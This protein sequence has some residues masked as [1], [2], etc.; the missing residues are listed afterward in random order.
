[1]GRTWIFE[2]TGEVRKVR[3]GDYYLDSAGHVQ[4]WIASFKSDLS[5]RILKLTKLSWNPIDPIRAVHEKWKGVVPTIRPPLNDF[6]NQC[7][8]AIKDAEGK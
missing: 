5:Y 3:S 7:W 6:E 2:E 8:Q 4:C 1:M